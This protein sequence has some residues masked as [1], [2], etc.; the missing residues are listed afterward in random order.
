MARHEYAG[1]AEISNGVVQGPV[2]QKNLSPLVILSMEK[3]MVAKVI[4]E[5]KSVSGLTIFF[6]KLGQGFRHF[7]LLIVHH[8]AKTYITEIL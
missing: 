7:E 8:I 1:N 5:L 4:R 6:Q 3:N 2:S